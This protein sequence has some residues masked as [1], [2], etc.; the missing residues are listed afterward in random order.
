MIANRIPTTLGE[1]P[2][3]MGKAKK[4]PAIEN[5]IKL[6]ANLLSASFL[7]GKKLKLAESTT[8]ISEKLEASINVIF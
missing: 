1:I 7:C 8:A 4:L 3:F 2:D 6:T 5:G